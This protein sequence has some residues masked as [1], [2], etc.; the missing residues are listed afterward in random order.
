MTI[1]HGT[2][3]CFPGGN[4]MRRKNVATV[5][6]FSEELTIMILVVDI[7]RRRQGVRTRTQDS[8]MVSNKQA[9]GP[10]IRARNQAAIRR[11]GE[12]GSR[13]RLVLLLNRVAGPVVFL[14]RVS[15]V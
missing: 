14:E 12:Q 7:I 1:N 8:T 4:G 3:V 9:K 6:A 10:V 15:H 5:V 2:R 13:G 11:G